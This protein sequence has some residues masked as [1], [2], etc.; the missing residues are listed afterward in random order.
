MALDLLASALGLPA[1]LPADARSTAKINLP[2][3]LPFRLG[4]A[5]GWSAPF[6][7]VNLQEENTCLELARDLLWQ[8]W[9][10]DGSPGPALAFLPACHANLSTLRTQA[11]AHAALWNAFAR[12]TVGLAN[13][14]LMGAIGTDEAVE[15][16]QLLAWATQQPA[17]AA[18]F[19]SAVIVE[20]TAA[21]TLDSIEAL[22]GA[23]ADQACADPVPDAVLPIARMV[24]V[25]VCHNDLANQLVNSARWLPDGSGLVLARTSLLG[26]LL[27]ASTLPMP[28]D[29]GAPAHPLGPFVFPGAKYFTVRDSVVHGAPMEEAVHHVRQTVTAVRATLHDI[30]R[31]LLSNA[32]RR[33]RVMQFIAAAIT[34]HATRAHSMSNALT[35]AGDGFLLNLLSVLLK[36]C[37]PFVKQTNFEKIDDC[38]LLR[39]TSLFGLGSDSAIAATTEETATARQAVPDAPAANPFITAVF[40]A[41]LYAIRVTVVPVADSMRRDWFNTDRDSEIEDSIMHARASHD[42]AAVAVLNQHRVEIAAM[43]P[44]YHAELNDPAYLDGV[45]QF[46][47]LV[48]RWLLKLLRWAPGPTLPRELLVAAPF[49]TLPDFVIENLGHFLM[50]LVRTD[51]TS[52]LEMSPDMQH[53]VSLLVTLVGVRST[54]TN[55]YLRAHLVAAIAAL[56]A[57]PRYSLPR[58]AA[59]FF[60]DAMALQLGPRLMEFYVDAENTDFYGKLTIRNHVQDIVRELWKMPLPRREIVRFSSDDF[61]VRFAMLMTNDVIFLLDEGRE[62]V[63]KI[64]RFRRE[65]SLSDG[66]ANDLGRARQTA[67]AVFSLATSSLDMLC[68]ITEEIVAPFLC[69]EVV[70]RLAAMLD[71]NIAALIDTSESEAMIASEYGLNLTEMLRQLSQIA[72]QVARL[73]RGPLQAPFIDALAREPRYYSLFKMRAAQSVLRT[74]PTAT[75]L[76]AQFSSLIDLVEAQRVLVQETDIPTE[77]IPDVFLDPIMIELMKDPVELPVSHTVVDRSTIAAHLLSQPE[78]PFNRAPLTLKDVIPRPD[79]KRRI[80][81][82]LAERAQRK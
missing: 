44:A 14:A 55:P 57:N 33:D 63:R 17:H 70:G 41:T 48:S 1:E 71:C 13:L 51:D 21:G 74:L 76:A 10:R 60:T 38:Y 69:P 58:T 52:V 56:V 39:P 68:Y 75:G 49:A 36:L 43:Q 20:A 3:K 80:E 64:Q 45:L 24:Y 2:H 47:G 42:Q 82:W 59:R 4:P 40:F 72:V 15:R 7:M 6:Q 66:D 18:D 12:A 67:R 78:D 32:A 53:V 77:E 22:V 79:I 9:T 54:L 31:K 34:R 30:F 61:F 73:T 81:E 37:E 27:A 16:Q 29:P 28:R 25:C 19:L 23:M 26:P 11:P 5:A 35:L 8:L 50:L 46:Y 65:T 62:A